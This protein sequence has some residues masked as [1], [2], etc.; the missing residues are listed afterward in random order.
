MAEGISLHI[1]E[2][3][4]GTLEADLNKELET[5]GRGFASALVYAAPEVKELLQKHI[6]RDV[7]DKWNPTEYQRRGFDGGIIDFEHNGS[8]KPSESS[9][10]GNQIDVAMKLRYKPDGVQEQW[11]V[12]A[13]GDELI[14]RIESGTGYEWKKH[15]GPRPFWT[16]FTNE[17]IEGG[18][19]AS[20]VF[21]GLT[22][23]GIQVDGFPEAVRQP[24]DGDY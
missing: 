20:Y 11:E 4:N 17:L 8:I 18:Y 5:L 12:P 2:Q 9:I 23:A 13:N 7:Y 21:S 16:N 15:P 6:Q 14:G 19:L 24:G 22:E 3:W 10:S 1:T